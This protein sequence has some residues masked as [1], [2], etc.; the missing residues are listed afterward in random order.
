VKRL[1]RILLKLL[2]LLIAA[3]LGL[4]L[5]MFVRQRSM[6]YYPTP[7]VNQ[8]AENSMSLAVDGAE[9]QIAVQDRKRPKA[10]IYFG[11]NAEEVSNSL[12]SYAQAFPEYAIYMMHYRGY[13]G[14]TGEPSEAALHADAAALFQMVQQ[15]HEQIEV[16]GRSLGSGIAVRLAATHPVHRLV[17]ITPFDSLVNVGKMHFPYMPV[18]LLLQERYESWRYAGQIQAPTT[19]LAAGADQIIPH[20]RT[21]ALFDAFTPGVATMQVLPHV[22]HNSISSNPRYME[23]IT[24]RAK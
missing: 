18:N 12:Q 17:L 7:G 21:Q 10:L 24:G 2:L 4:C 20:A 16:V 15:K 8:A 19:I 5:I 11:G 6:I 9:L 1:K 14:S 23:F 13:S 22:D 3:Y